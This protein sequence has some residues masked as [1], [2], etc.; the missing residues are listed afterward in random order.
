MTLDEL[1]DKAIN[2]AIQK[3]ESKDQ[4]IER[5]RPKPFRYLT[6]EEVK[7]ELSIQNLGPASIMKTAYTPLTIEND[8]SIISLGDVN[9]IENVIQRHKKI[10]MLR[11]NQE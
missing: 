1:V 6:D 4:D 7:K 2:D 9:T 3:N 10:R 8:I 5:R 11:K